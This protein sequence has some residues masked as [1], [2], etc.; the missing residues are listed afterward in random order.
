MGILRR[1][2]GDFNARGGNPDIERLAS[3]SKGITAGVPRIP[4]LGLGLDLTLPRKPCLV[5]SLLPSLQAITPPK[6]TCPGTHRWSLDWLVSPTR[7]R[8]S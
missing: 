7:T 3:C 8:V 2:S 5:I 1:A 4:Y 6:C